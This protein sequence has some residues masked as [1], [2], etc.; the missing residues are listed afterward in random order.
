MKTNRISLCS[1][2]AQI[3]IAKTIASESRNILYRFTKSEIS[4]GPALRLHSG[5]KQAQWKF[6]RNGRSQH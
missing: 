4:T 6:E 1:T 5:R 3:G 2:L